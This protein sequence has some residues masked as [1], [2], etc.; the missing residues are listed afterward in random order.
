MLFLIPIGGGIPGGVLLARNR[1]LEWP[2]MMALYFISDLILACV[3]EPLMLAVIALGKRSLFVNQMREAFKKAMEMTTPYYGSKLGPLALI[4][5]TFGTDPMT[6]RAVTVTA[7]HGFFTG[8]TL[9]IIGDMLYFSVLMVSTLWLNNILG[10]G[11]WTT[12]IILALMMIVPV[13]VRRFREL[14]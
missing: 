4:M 10:D 11:T 2:A 13:L 5:V 12:L 14:R 1:G 8:W 7:G 3:F 9:A 6:G